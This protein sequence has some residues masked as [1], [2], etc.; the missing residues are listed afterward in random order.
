MTHIKLCRAR[1]DRGSIKPLSSYPVL[2]HVRIASRQRKPNFNLKPVRSFYPPPFLFS[3]LRAYLSIF[4]WCRQISWSSPHPPLRPS[5]T[6]SL[7]H[8]RCPVYAR[9]YPIPRGYSTII[10]LF[11]TG[12]SPSHWWISIPVTQ[13]LH[14]QKIS[15]ARRSF[16][17]TKGWDELP[18]GS[19]I[20]PRSSR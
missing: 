19:T 1:S 13:F 12:Y 4:L 3:P 16:F 5:R 7:L 9:P 6:L 17:L 11:R 2:T 14:T 18:Q 15:P 10:D 20:R 8:L